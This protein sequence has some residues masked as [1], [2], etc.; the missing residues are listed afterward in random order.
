MEEIEERA[1]KSFEKIGFKLDKKVMEDKARL[2]KQKIV[3]NE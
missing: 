2:L 3:R 1:F